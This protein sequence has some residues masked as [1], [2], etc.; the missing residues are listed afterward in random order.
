MKKIIGKNMPHCNQFIGE[1]HQIFK[2]Y[3]EKEG[4]FINSL[5]EAVITLI[6][7]SKRITNRFLF[8]Y[9]MIN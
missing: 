8:I 7:K 9:R 1:F 5:L 2:D 6:L 4:I 3:L